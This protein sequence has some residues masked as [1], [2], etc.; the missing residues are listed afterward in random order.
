MFSKCESRI[1]LL[2]DDPSAA[3]NVLEKIGFSDFKIMD[4]GRIKI[5]EQFD[6]TGDITLALASQ[7]VTTL[8]IVRKLE[9]VENYYMRLVKGT[10]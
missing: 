7:G 1:E 4:S 2:T 3:G 8:E 10:E 5:Y 6:R 9:S